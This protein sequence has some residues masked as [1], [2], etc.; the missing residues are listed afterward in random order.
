MALDTRGIGTATISAESA[1]PGDLP[2]VDV[3]VSD[4]RSFITASSHLTLGMRTSVRDIHGD[5]G[6]TYA[7][8]NNTQ[9]RFSATRQ[10]PSGTELVFDWTSIQD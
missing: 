6:V 2:Y 4:T 9:C 7:F 3:S 10:L 1:G 5:I 8:L